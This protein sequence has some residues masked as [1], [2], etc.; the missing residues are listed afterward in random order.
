MT[1]KHNSGEPSADGKGPEQGTTEL[2]WGDRHVAKPNTSESSIAAPAPPHQIGPYRILEELG[3]GGMGVVYL[4]EQTEPVR[5]RI[6]L[7]MLQTGLGSRKLQVRFEAERQAMARLHHPNVAQLYEASDTEDGQ[8][9]FAMELVEGLPVTD[10]CDRKRLNIRER[11]EIFQDIC[12]GVQHAHE[13][14]LIHRDL[15][16]ANILVT[17]E[18][19][20]PTPKVL[21]FGIAK[22]IDQPLVEGTLFTGEQVIGTPA[23]LSPEA[24][25]TVGIGFDLDTRSDVYSL[26]ILLYELLVG[27]RP[28][29]TK[30]VAL[31][32]VLK[33]ITEKEHT[34]PSTR[35]TALAGDTRAG[36]AE[37]RRHDAASL[38]KRLKGDLDWIVLKAI[39]K[40]RRERYSSAADLAADIDRHLHN[41]PVEAS[42]PSTLYRVGKFVRRRRGLVLAAALVLISLLTGLFGTIV[43]LT[44]AQQEAE[45]ANQEASVSGEIADFLTDLF[46]VTDPGEARGNSITARELLDRGSEKIDEGFAEQPLVR[47]RFM[48]IIGEV[49]KKL[50]LYDQAQPLLEGALEIREAQLE[51]EHLDV[52]TAL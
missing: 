1:D 11:L 42:P 21:D 40:D 37:T 6:A 3:R 20:K 22:A 41:L 52:A 49:F 33:Q 30:G 2:G 36:I 16:P 29:E 44:R 19:D 7:K 45:R 14:G 51:D 50:G 38:S 46:E 48:L 10:Y 17:E 47:A 12:R 35:W 34:G 5:R 28:F 24:V 23:Y 31:V 26:G 39:A 32:K 15:K 43:G 18:N 25:E 9:Y 8:P 13:K 4:A 27:V